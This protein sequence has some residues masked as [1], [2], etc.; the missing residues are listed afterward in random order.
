MPPCSM[1]C[2]AKMNK[3]IVTNGKGSNAVQALNAIS[4]NGI[5]AIIRPATVAIPAANGIGTPII[6]V[7]TKTS[8]ITI[9]P[10]KN[11]IIKVNLSNQF[12]STP[13]K[14]QKLYRP[15]NKK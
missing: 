11:S 4:D 3:G 13:S 9:G 5:S 7:K 15:L 10:L 1:S 2:P 14:L 8:A 12:F 6:I